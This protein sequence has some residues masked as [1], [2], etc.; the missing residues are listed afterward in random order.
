MLVFCIWELLVT[1]FS[2][3]PSMLEAGGERIA[4]FKKLPTGKF[5]S[6]I[7]CRSGGTAH[8]LPGT[9]ITL[10]CGALEACATDYLITVTAAGL[11]SH[12]STMA[13][14]RISGNNFGSPAAG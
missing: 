8:S 3:A 6:W 10:F 11:P 7:C 4:G 13:G 5:P 9:M 14:V 2:F 12:D 1:S